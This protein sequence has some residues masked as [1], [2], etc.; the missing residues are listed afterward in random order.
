[1]ADLLL[2]YL[3]LHGF[4]KSDAPISIEG[5]PEG[6]VGPRLP[7]R[8]GQRSSTALRLGWDIKM[9]P[10]VKEDRRADRQ[11]EARSGTVARG[12]SGREQGQV[13]AKCGSWPDAQLTA[14]CVALRFTAAAVKITQQ[15]LTSIQTAAG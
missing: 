14:L 10:P 7:G 8:R 11:A 3:R 15:L 5:I 6:R 2:T 9:D 13:L 4:H 1:M 12:I